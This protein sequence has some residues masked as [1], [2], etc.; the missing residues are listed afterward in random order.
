MKWLRKRARDYAVLLF[1][2]LGF[3]LYFLF[4]MRTTRV[5]YLLYLDLLLF[6]LWAIA[7]GAAFFVYRERERRKQRFLKEKE[8]IFDMLS[9]PDDAEVFAHDLAILEQ[10]IQNGFDANCDLQDYVAKW[11]HEFKIPLAAA[12]LLSDK[13]N[14]TSVRNSIREQ[15]ERMNLQVNQMLQG[16]RLQSPLFDLQVRQVPLSE[17]VRTSIRNNQFF[18]IR[19]KF[20]MD[21]AVGDD[22][23]I[24]TDET[25]LTYILDQILSNAVKYAKAT[26]ETQGGRCIRIWCER[27]DDLVTLWI[28][29]NGEGIAQCDIRRVFEK[30][31]TGSNYHNGKYKSTGMGLYLAAQ[32]AQKLEHALSV[33]SVCGEYTRFCV[34]MRAG[35][36]GKGEDFTTFP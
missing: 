9:M 26:D 2:V 11:C 23:T 34:V 17:C 16:C 5:A 30:G 8:L 24:Y 32:I 28:E 21:V 14:D 3:N 27:E 35:S 10:R 7:E 33:E 1:F 4:L 22:V 13:I 6:V 19:N 29:D 25:W 20:Q 15:L 36:L 12:L 31:Y 18:L